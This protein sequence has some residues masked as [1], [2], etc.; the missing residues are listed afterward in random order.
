VETSNELRSV[1]IR[2]GLRSV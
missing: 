2:T 1:S